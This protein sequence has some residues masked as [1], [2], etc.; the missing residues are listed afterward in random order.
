[1]KYNR[2]K[3]TF[4]DVNEHCGNTKFEVARTVSIKIKVFSTGKLVTE[5]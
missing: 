4:T 5:E 3:M 2:K 1:M